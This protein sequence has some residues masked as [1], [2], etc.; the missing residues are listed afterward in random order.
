MIKKLF[1]LILSF[2]L[3]AHVTFAET[4]NLNEEKSRVNYIFSYLNVPVKKKFLPA[5]GHI[6][7]VKGDNNSLY[8]KGLDLDVNFTSK[9]SVFKKA[10]DYDKYPDFKFWAELETP[11]QLSDEEFVE[12]EGYL[13]FHGVTE[14]IKINLKNKI[15]DEGISLIGFFNMKMT[16]FGIKPPKIFFIVLDDIIKSKVELFSNSI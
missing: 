1:I 11:V 3:T 8:L 2:Y 9:S 5:T 13:S 6:N 16:D 12:L 7:L 4:T 14:K 15:I 10:I